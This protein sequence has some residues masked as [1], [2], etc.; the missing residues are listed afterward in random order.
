VKKGAPVRI[1]AW[2]GQHVRNL[3][4]SQGTARIPVNLH[5]VRMLARQ[6]LVKVIVNRKYA[7][8]LMKSR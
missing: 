2:M 6:A 5:H 7:N 4:S 1:P 8:R 3:A